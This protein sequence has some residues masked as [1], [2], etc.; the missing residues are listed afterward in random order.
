MSWLLA[1]D[2]DYP[3]TGYLTSL[4]ASTHSLIIFIS[5]AEMSVVSLGDSPSTL[6]TYVKFFV[7]GIRVTWDVGVSTMEPCVRREERRLCCTCSSLTL[8]GT[9]KHP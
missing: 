6:K 2:L 1:A 7:P 8:P 3:I 4:M 5:G 9:T